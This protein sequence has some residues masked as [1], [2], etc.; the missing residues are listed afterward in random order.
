[1]NGV[2]TVDEDVLRRAWAAAADTQ[3]DLAPTGALLEGLPDDDVRLPRARNLLLR[4]RPV[5]ALALLPDVSRDEVVGGRVRGWADLVAAACWAAQGDER[6]LGALMLQGADMTGGAAQSHAYLVGA[7]AEQ[8]GRWEV[9]DQA[10]R[11]LFDHAPVT[12]HVFVRALA[13]QVARRDPR[14]PA[15]AG[16]DVV[17]AAQALLNWHGADPY[18]IARVRQVADLLVARDDRVGAALLT[19]AL[20][21]MRPGN[22]RLA[23][24]HQDHPV[25]RSALLEHGA[26][27]VGVLAGGALVA[28]GVITDLPGVVVLLGVALALLAPVHRLRT[29]RGLGPV[30]DRVL[31]EVDGVPLDAPDDVPWLA[32]APWWVLL[33][34]LLPVSA[35]VAFL[36]TFAVAIPLVPSD[37]ELGDDRTVDGVVSAVT[38]VLT[39]AILALLLRLRRRNVT[40]QAQTRRAADHQAWTATVGECRC[41]TDEAFRAPLA[42]EYLTRH[43]HPSS[44][45]AA[46]AVARSV[47]GAVAAQCPLTGARWLVLHDPDEEVRL[48]LRG[49]AVVTPEPA[50]AREAGGYL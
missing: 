35:L 39:V 21:R 6:A 44:D 33:A 42:G 10:W 11:L 27:V 41:W 3:D 47:E 23:A 17:D 29:A 40:R 14:D 18:G 22:E 4:G 12:D 34:V 25:R 24:V 9:A 36:V 26:Q 31:R 5:D 30:D 37:V 19:R 16:A 38:V 15:R 20:V 43:L 50:A 13:A 7:A 48:V 46:T 49:P 8:A 2:D 1:V 28:I 45:G 32:R